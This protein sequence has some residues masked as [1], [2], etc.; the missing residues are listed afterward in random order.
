MA[1]RKFKNIYV[2][3]LL[4]VVSLDTSENTGTFE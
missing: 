4:T 1:T 2:L 3:H